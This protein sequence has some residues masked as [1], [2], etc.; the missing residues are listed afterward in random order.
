MI[1]SLTGFFAA[2]EIEK[3]YRN[4]SMETFFLEI[5]EGFIEQI[6]TTKDPTDV[7]GPDSKGTEWGG[8]CCNSGLV[9]RIFYDDID[10]GNFLINFLPNTIQALQ[11]T[12]AHQVYSLQ[13]RLLPRNLSELNLSG[14]LIFGTVNLTELPTSIR[15]VNLQANDLRAPVSL[16][17]LPKRLSLLNIGFNHIKQKVVYYRELPEEIERIDITATQ[18]SL[19][20]PI[21]HEKSAKFKHIFDGDSRRTKIE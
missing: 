15:F 3:R 5:N 21:D 10:V 12:R 7:C 20:R 13:A 19:L 2:R 1:T 11:L 16:V 8:I 4:I 9:F 18:I 14:N 17:G 6:S